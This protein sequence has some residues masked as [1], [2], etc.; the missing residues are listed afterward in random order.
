MTQEEIKTIIINNKLEDSV[1]KL[2]N[3][4]TALEK[5]SQRMSGWISVHDNPPPNADNPGIT[6]GNFLCINDWNRMMVCSITKTDGNSYTGYQL[7]G[8]SLPR[9]THYMRLPSEP[10]LTKTN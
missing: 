2:F 9:I 10:I 5:D 4:I 3:L 1:I 7:N 8:S 6:D